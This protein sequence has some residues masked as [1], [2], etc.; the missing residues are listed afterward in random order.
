MVSSTGAH[1]PTNNAYTPAPTSPMT[2]NGIGT[3]RSRRSWIVQTK[4]KA[5][6]AMLAIRRLSFPFYYER[7]I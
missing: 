1:N 6:K 3:S 4:N 7:S 2:G 5:N